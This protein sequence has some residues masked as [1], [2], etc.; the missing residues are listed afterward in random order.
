MAQGSDCFPDQIAAR[1]LTAFHGN[2]Q[3]TMVAD[4]DWSILPIALGAFTVLYIAA[5]FCIEKWRHGGQREPV[6]WRG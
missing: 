5:W 3:R 6:A 4:M 1:R 2:R